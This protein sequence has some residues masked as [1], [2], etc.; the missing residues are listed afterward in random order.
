[1]NCCVIY[2]LDEM[3]TAKKTQKGA[4][5]MKKRLATRLDDGNNEF[6]LIRIDED[7]FHGYSNL[8]KFKNV[9]DPWIINEGGST[10]IMDENYEWLQ[11]YPDNEKYAITVAFD[12]NHNLI[13]WYFDMIKSSDLENGVPYF[14]DLYLDY[15]IRANGNKIVFDEDEL[16]AALKSGDISNDDVALAYSTMNKIKYM[17]DKNIESLIELTNNIYNKF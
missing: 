6:K 7:F 3:Y 10:C 16:F 15:V 11:I 4:V 8:V 17:Y 12:E 9:K 2:K 13:E 1:M 14:F 5:F